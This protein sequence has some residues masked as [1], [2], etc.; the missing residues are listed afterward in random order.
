MAPHP[1]AAAGACTSTAQA[2]ASRMPSPSYTLDD[3]SCA[4]HLPLPTLAECSLPLISMSDLVCKV[5]QEGP[6]HIDQVQPEF[7]GEHAVG[8]HRS[9]QVL[10]AAVLPSGVISK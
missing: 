3:F 6:L 8:C 1:G 7:K 9:Q 5:L 2:P 4:P 10:W